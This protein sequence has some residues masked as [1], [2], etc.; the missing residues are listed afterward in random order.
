MNTIPCLVQ[1]LLNMLDNLQHAFL[2]TCKVPILLQLQLLPEAVDQAALHAAC[3]S[4]TA[5]SSITVS[6]TWQHC[7]HADPFWRALGKQT[8]LRS[9][10]TI[11]QWHG[12]EAHPHSPLEA[13]STEVLSAN[14]T[15]EYQQCVAKLSRSESLSVLN[16]GVHRIQK[17]SA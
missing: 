16:Q 2:S 8:R 5:T 11:W 13:H 12:Y 4:I 14:L 9:L 1:E 17:W 15:A 6:S 10:E 7:S 3:P